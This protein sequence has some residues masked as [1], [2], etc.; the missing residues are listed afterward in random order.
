MVY[1]PMVLERATGRGGEGELQP[2]LGFRIARIATLGFG[3]RPPESLAL[4]L[5]W[6]LA[7]D[8]RFPTPD[9]RSLPPGPAARREPRP[10]EQPPLSPVP[11]LLSPRLPP[12]AA[13]PWC[14]QSFRCA[15]K[16]A[17]IVRA[18]RRSR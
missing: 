9:P 6:R 3:L 4:E 11:C 14:T 16:C 2:G 1:P 15:G 7:P 10:P 18:T 13:R 8:C 17:A 12:A 5:Q